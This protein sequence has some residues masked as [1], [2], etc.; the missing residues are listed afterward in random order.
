VKAILA[1]SSVASSSRFSSLLAYPFAGSRHARFVTMKKTTRGRSP[2]E[3]SY[4]RATGCRTGERW[5]F[6][7][8]SER[9]FAFGST[10][11][12]RRA[13]YLTARGE[14]RLLSL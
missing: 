10:E 12:L 8:A 5:A 1:N 9:L 14:M 7:L 6:S 11:H 3:S 2:S 13:A 4:R